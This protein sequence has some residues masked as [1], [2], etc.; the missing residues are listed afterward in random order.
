MN[1]Y[2]QSVL[3]AL[4]DND[5]AVRCSWPE[6][7]ADALGLDESAFHV[8]LDPDFQA[9]CRGAFKIFVWQGQDGRIRLVDQLAIRQPRGL[10]A[11]SRERCAL[12]GMHD[13]ELVPDTEAFDSGVHRVCRAPLAKWRN[14]NGE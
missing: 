5:S 14:Q 12:C 3:Q 8:L 7:F 2:E 9:H 11:P 6:H 10:K 4:I 1:E 13:Q